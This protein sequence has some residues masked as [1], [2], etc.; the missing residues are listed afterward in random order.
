MKSDMQTAC[1]LTRMRAEFDEAKRY[2]LRNKDSESLGKYQKIQKEL[3][4][5]ELQ[6]KELNLQE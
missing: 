2:Y 4:L 5:M 6:Q 3:W 1:S